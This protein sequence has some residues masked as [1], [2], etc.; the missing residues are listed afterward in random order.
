LILTGEPEAP[1][2]TSQAL[3]ITGGGFLGL[4]S[5]FYLAEVEKSIGCPI[6]SLFDLVAGT[7][8]GGITALAIAAEIPLERVVSFFEEHGP[9]I[10]SSRRAPQ[11]G[12]GRFSDLWKSVIK[13]KYSANPLRAAIDELFGTGTLLGDLKHPIVVPALNM[14]QGSTKVF[15]TPHNS[16]FFNDWE[17]TVLDVAMATSAAPTFFP[18][19]EV[20]DELYVDGGLFAN[21]PDLVAYHELTQFLDAKSSEIRMLSIGTTMAKY[22][23]AHED[24][25]DYGSYKWM[26]DAR[27]FSTM[28]S[29]QQ[30]IT[31]FMMSHILGDRY[32]RIDKEQAKEQERFLKLDSASPAT[33]KE[34]RGLAASAWRESRDQLG[35]VIAFRAKQP[36]FFHGSGK[37]PAE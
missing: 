33:I 25:V 24:G 12:I 3:C 16:R 1:A 20:R 32:I 10:F 17:L 6:A 7:S 5:A 35:D 37:S 19:A 31:E 30:Q 34:L 4:F 15:K 29:A 36:A 23:L 9:T 26:L 8:I 27:L 2:V 18:I 13:P 11:S 28:L 21:A 14:T 22:S